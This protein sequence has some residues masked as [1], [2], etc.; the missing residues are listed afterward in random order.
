MQ[1]SR[2][3]PGP[4]LGESPRPPRRRAGL[5]GRGTGTR[6]ARRPTGRFPSTASAQPRR[7][8]QSFVF[9]PSLGPGPA[10]PPATGFFLLPVEKP[11][12]AAGGRAAVS[13]AVTSATDFLLS[14]REKLS[15]LTVHP[16]LTPSLWVPWV[17]PKPSGTPRITQ[18]T[19]FSGRWCWGLISVGSRAS[20]KHPQPHE[21]DRE[22]TQAALD[23]ALLFFSSSWRDVWAEGT[24][25]RSR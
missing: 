23:K 20:S 4:A 2:S 3:P 18:L 11:S 7:R 15:V 24:H 14:C 17:D 13:A 22:L 5:G 16:Q 21:Q 9:F 12:G 19:S 25:R 8:L 6:R 10:L 1:T